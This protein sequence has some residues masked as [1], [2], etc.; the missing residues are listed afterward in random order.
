MIEALPRFRNGRYNGHTIY[1]Q[2]DEDPADT[3]VF[4][5]SCT[6]RGMAFSL[7]QFANVG[8]AQMQSVNQGNPEIADA[9]NEIHIKAQ[10]AAENW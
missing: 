4:V 9:L 10:R 1:F 6:T 7:V 3:D 2:I 5:G 8:L